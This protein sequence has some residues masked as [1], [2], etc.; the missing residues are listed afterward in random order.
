MTAAGHLYAVPD[1]HAPEPPLSEVQRDVLSMV[2]GFA[3]DHL[4]EGSFCAD[5]DTLAE[6]VCSDHAADQDRIGDFLALAREL[7]IEVVS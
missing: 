5:C 7:G 3:I 4:A 1:Q 6:G 2:F